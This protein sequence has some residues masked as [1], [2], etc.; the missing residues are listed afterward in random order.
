MLSLSRRIRGSA[1][2]RCMITKQWR[3]QT[4]LAQWIVLEKQ[5]GIAMLFARA[6]RGVFEAAEQSNRAR[7]ACPRSP[8]QTELI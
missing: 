1:K 5:D 4:V 8:Q 2:L 6:D 3:R 7:G